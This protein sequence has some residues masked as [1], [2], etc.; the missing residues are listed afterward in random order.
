MKIR[1]K[2]LMSLWKTLKIIVEHPLNRKRKPQ[3]LLG[4]LKWQIGSRLVPGEVIFHWVNGAKF[5]ARP[6]E[7]GLTQNIYCGLQELYEMTY[8]LHVLNSE[9]LFIDVGANAGSYT[10]LACAVRGAKGYCFEPVP[11]TYL[12]L[13]DNIKLNDLSSRVK[14]YNIG[15]SD[16]ESELFFTAGQDT[17]NHVIADGESTVDAIKVKVL[18]L[19]ILLA[20]EL[21]TIIKIDVEGLETLVV[22]G[23]LH[24]LENP[25]LHS[26][27]MELNGSGKRYGFDEEHLIEKM[28]GFGFQT[29]SYD[30]FCRTLT[31]LGG[32]NAQSGNT[33]FLRNESFI[34][35]RI[36]SAP[37]INI[38]SLEI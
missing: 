36:A 13:M 9:D 16:R 8:V 29:Y 19:D 10:I 27:I 11:S 25:S 4:F 37:R 34:S 33:L 17:R 38:G 28:Q 23:M 2:N 30:P 31:P 20:G 32:K 7:T 5:I 14:A 12:R 6:G 15:L 24:T 1:R 35:E 21:P 3:A 18:P 26:V 22:N